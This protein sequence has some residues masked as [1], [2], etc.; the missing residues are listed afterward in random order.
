MLGWGSKVYCQKC[1]KAMTPS[2]QKPVLFSQDLFEVTF[3]C[4]RLF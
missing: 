1:R 3:I 2:Q 4:K